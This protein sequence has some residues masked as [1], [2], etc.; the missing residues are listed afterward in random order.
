MQPRSKAFTLISSN[1]GCFAWPCGLSRTFLCKNIFTLVLIKYF[2][3]NL[4]RL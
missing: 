2:S 1:F 3:A 4:S